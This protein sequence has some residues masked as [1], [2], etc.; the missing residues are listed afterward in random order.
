MRN[1]TQRAE[2]LK[3][4]RSKRQHCSA[5]QIYDA[6]REKI[7]NI[8]LGTV[9][10]NLGQLLEQGEIISVEAVDKCIY[11]DGFAEDHAHFV[12]SGC[13]EIYDFPIEPEKRTSILE[14]GFSVD[15]ERVIYY[16]KCSKCKNSEKSVK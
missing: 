2:I 3:F 6:V 1:T 7:P 9:Y 12:C 11:Y 10:R 8:S 5:V 16:G 4:L 14:A 15:S 13:K